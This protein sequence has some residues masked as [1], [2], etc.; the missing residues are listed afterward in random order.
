MKTESTK[1][2]NSKHRA[3]N[4]SE[5]RISFDSKNRSYLP[6]HLRNKHQELKQRERSH[7]PYLDESG[8]NHSIKN[9][10]NQN[11][12]KMGQYYHN[13]K[14]LENVL[15][16]EKEALNKR[17]KEKQQILQRKQK[18]ASYSKLVKEIHWDS[19]SEKARDKLN[20]QPKKKRNLKTEPSTNKTFEHKPS[21]KM[22]AIERI[23]SMRNNKQFNEQGEQKENYVNNSKSKLRDSFEDSPE[24]DRRSIKAMKS[25]I[26]HSV[27]DNLPRSNKHQDSHN[28]IGMENSEF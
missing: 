12:N 21:S 24:K 11:K 5:A 22:S 16:E 14:A 3:N 20:H 19:T 23:K 10:E 17:E 26:H 2:L 4:Y 8:D 7:G 27:K 9:A 1:N 6:S 13:A 28:F 25:E 15:K 18:V